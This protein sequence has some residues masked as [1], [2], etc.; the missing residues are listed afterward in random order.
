MDW[1]RLTPESITATGQIILAATIAL[2]LFSIKK[3][4]LVL[5]LLALSL[6]AETL[7]HT[8]KW[9]EFSFPYAYTSMGGLLALPSFFIYTV[10]IAFAYVYKG[11]LYMRESY[12]VLAISGTISV[13]LT[14]AVLAIFFSNQPH[15]AIPYAERFFYI[16]V[17][18]LMISS[19]WAI[20]VLLRKARFF[21]A[22]FRLQQHTITQARIGD[23]KYIQP[24][25]AASRSCIAF[26]TIFSIKLV[27]LGMAILSQYDV[28]TESARIYA[29]LVLH[30]LYLCG[31]MVVIIDHANHPTSL[32]VKLVG[33][34]LSIALLLFSVAALSAHSTRSL[35]EQTASYVTPQ[36]QYLFTPGPNNAYTV[37]HENMAHSSPESQTEAFANRENIPVTLSFPFPF[38][39]QQWRTIY[40][41]RHGVISFIEAFHAREPGVYYM[42]QAYP[43]YV[44]SLS[45]QIPADIPLIMPLFHRS[46]SL[47]TDSLSILE[48]DDSVTLT[49]L[50]IQ[51]Q[52]EDI[53][54]YI[55]ARPRESSFFARLYH[56]GR[57]VIGHLDLDVYL[58]DGHVG[59]QPGN[60]RNSRAIHYLESDLDLPLSTVSANQGIVLD[61]FR[62]F[63][64]EIHDEVA[65]L[66]WFMVVA[67]VLILAVFPL[68][69][70]S[71]IFRPL[72]YLLDGVQV[73]N[74]GHYDVQVPVLTHDEIGYVTHNFNG[75]VTS[76]RE[77]QQT[78]LAHNEN[79]EKEVAA[80]T[81]E[82][83]QQK[84]QLEIQADQLREMDAIKSRFFAN[85][86]HEF[87]APLNLIIN[88][89]EFALSGKYGAINPVLQ[90]HHEVILNESERLLRLINQL[91]DLAKFDAGRLELQKKNL[92]LVPFVER[93][94]HSFES[95]A[96]SEEKTLRFRSSEASLVGGFDMEKMENIFYNL[97]DNALKF[98]NEGGKVLVS[99]EPVE[100][101]ATNSDTPQ[102][103][104]AVQDTGRG[105]PPEH[106]ER[107]FDRFS[108]ADTTAGSSIHPGTGIGL[109]LVQKLVALHE[110]TIN[111][112]SDVGFGTTFTIE[113]PLLLSDDTSET[114]DASPS[115]E[116]SAGAPESDIDPPSIPSHVEHAERPPI[117]SLYATAPDEER[118]EKSTRVLIVDDDHHF[119]A[120]IC[121]YL[122]TFYTVE[123]AENGRKGLEKARTH[124][125]DI[126]ISDVLMPEM[127]GLEFCDAVRADPKLDH[128]P[129]IMLT[130]KASIESRIEGLEQ[131]ADD[132]LAKP[133]NPNELYACITNR[134][135]QR[136]LLI[137]KYTG[138]VRLEASN[139]VVDSADA[140]FIKDVVQIVDA[141]LNDPGFNVGRLAGDM[142][143]SERDLQR[144]LRRLLDKSPKDV[145]TQAR[146][147]RAKQLLAQQFG[148]NQQIAR[149]TGFRR[150]DHFA[151]VFKK[152][153]GLTP[154]EY[155]NQQ[156]SQ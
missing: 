107:I 113:M 79:L 82:V 69:A 63:R 41:N 104:M 15:D 126:I 150:A 95:R 33:L 98:T 109:A 2:Y 35:L 28:I 127:D 50:G 154:G 142:E 40:V 24:D 80:R 66:L 21:T 88:P 118:I 18:F 17:I 72:R 11:K 97:I 128:I 108:Q 143:V 114:F 90:R 67:V 34:T 134:L 155:A 84:Q 130:A 39:G 16:I 153:T 139:I 71:S 85:I 149:M 120:L 103:R 96:I 111:V 117:P 70:Q 52:T 64:T 146:I 140:A 93:I 122:D 156:T 138:M 57:I 106:I 131:G 81:E 136:R 37:T 13:L 119:R 25:L 77:A 29:N 91:L 58:Y 32:Q 116:L 47:A 75:M 148:T 48:S 94:V 26:A 121:E 19:T 145:I 45:R 55:G 1:F 110:G 144:K 12:I 125:P 101:P 124:P 123:A 92:D 7:H 65:R 5:W 86:S 76:L 44:P 135:T 141:S 36:H 100:Q 115:H 60:S 133:F 8:I 38:Y 102:V 62:R 129:F 151:R 105:I 4:N 87:R 27:I 53:D 46:K 132:Y 78:L 10:L 43:H 14:G 68:I 42:N 9:V 83:V 59:I 6:V 49:W 152:H 99:I 23:L 61:Y 51:Q 20:V 137:E 73:V 56:D 89:I 74:E 22:R 147:D 112:D 54:P 3:K 30:I 31:L